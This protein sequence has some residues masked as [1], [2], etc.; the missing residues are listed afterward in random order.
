MF[1]LSCI[2]TAAFTTGF[3]YDGNRH[4]KA[5]QEYEELS[6]LIGR[7]Q[8]GLLIEVDKTSRLLIHF[9]KSSGQVIDLHNLSGLRTSYRSR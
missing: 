4:V 1:A 3:Y 9:D 5:V 8:S 2:F 6:K 7:Q